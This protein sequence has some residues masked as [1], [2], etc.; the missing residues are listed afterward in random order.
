[1]DFYP[2]L[3]NGSFDAASVVAYLKANP[4]IQYMLVLNEPNLVGQSNLTP[5]QAAKL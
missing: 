4:R 5:Q 3:W 1:M 2:M